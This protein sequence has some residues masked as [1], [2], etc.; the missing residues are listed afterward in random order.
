V[1]WIVLAA[2]GVPLW[3]CAAA[4]LTLL[5][6]NRKLRVR[7]GDIAVRRRSSGKK[8]WTRGHAVWMHDV[9]AYRGSPA[10]WSESLIWV[11][12]ASI[13]GVADPTEA[14]MLRRLGEHPA[15]VLLKAEDGSTV[16]VA[17]PLARAIDLL[18]PFAVDA[19]RPPRPA[20]T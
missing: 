20:P 8:R 5:V 14:K 9:F 18:G 4:L 6:R 10:M 3:L 2:L 15:I 13:R 16:E 1:I 12:E 19:A 7:G 17:A 11:T